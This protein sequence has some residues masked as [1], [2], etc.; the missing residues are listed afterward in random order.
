MP[1]RHL[2]QNLWL[3]TE[4]ESL[5]HHIL[6]KQAF[7]V[8]RMAVDPGVGDVPAEGM[9][10]EGAPAT[11]AHDGLGVYDVWRI[12]LHKYEV[13]LIAFADESAPA[14]LI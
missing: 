7:G 12:G 11:F 6:I 8:Y 13:G 9:S 3:S 2:P 1:R 14:H 4:S 10:L 5:P